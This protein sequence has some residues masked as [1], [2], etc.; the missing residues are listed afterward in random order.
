MEQLRVVTE[1]KDEICRQLVSVKAERDD[2]YR[3]AETRKL[4][5]ERKNSEIRFLIEQ[6]KYSDLLEK[7]LNTTE[8]LNHDRKFKRK[9]L[10][11]FFIPCEK[12]PLFKKLLRKHKMKHWKESHSDYYKE[13][14]NYERNRVKLSPSNQYTNCDLCKKKMK[15]CS[16][17]T[18]K[19]KSHG[20]DLN[21]SPIVENRKEEN[22]C[23]ICGHM[24]KYVRDLKTHMR[25]VHERKLDY[26]CKYCMKKFCN[27]GNLNKHELIHTGATPFQ[28]DVCGKQFRWKNL[29]VKHIVSHT[30]SGD[31][32]ASK[33]DYII[34]P[35]TKI[36]SYVEIHNTESSSLLKYLALQKEEDIMAQTDIVS[37]LSNGLL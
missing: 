22:T 17:K 6:A 8:F 7:G 33:W 11:T 24:S 18:H 26:S 16:I 35:D 10:K 30:K 9:L 32:V 21:N 27:R 3:L 37:L 2:Y 23:K 1:D 5:V 25:I 14:R 4:E 20:V 28:C 36:H 29:L 19:I 13:I 15:V 34:T 31:G 12:C